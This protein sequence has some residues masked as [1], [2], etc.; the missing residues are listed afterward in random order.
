MDRH[1]KKTD[2]NKTVQGKT[3]RFHISELD[4]A[5]EVAQIRK[6]L[7]GFQGIDSLSFHILDSFVEVE[8]SPEVT[9]TEAI[10][11]QLISTGWTATLHNNSYQK[12]TESFWK[13]NNRLILTILA[14]LFLFMGVFSNFILSDHKFSLNVFRS[15]SHSETDLPLV[16]Q[17]FYLLSITFGGFPV[18]LRAIKSVQQY[19]ADMN[20]L[21]TVA[22]I[23]AL[24]IN[25]WL[26][27][28]MVTFLFAISL[29]LESWSTGQAKKAISNLVSHMP[30]KVLHRTQSE[31]DSD[32]KESPVS[33]IK[34]GDFIQVQPGDK[35]PLDGTVINGESLVD[36]SPITGESVPVEKNEG[37]EVFAGTLNTTGTLEIQVTKLSDESLLANIQK[38]VL[39]AQANQAPVEQTV[40]KFAR[41]YTPIMLVISFLIMTV[42]PL[43]FHGVWS[44]WFYK[45]LVILVIACPCALVISTP[46][47][48]VSALSSAAR[49][50]I[51]IKGGRYLEQAA[52][53]KTIA[54][55][56]T[57][58]ITFGKPVIEKII[59]LNNYQE[60]QLLEIAASI[61]SHSPHPFSN[62]IVNYAINN[63]ISFKQAEEYQYETGQ[64]GRGIVH[65]KEYWVGGLRMLKN[66][67]PGNLDQIEKIRNWETEGF[68][69][70]LIGNKDHLAGCILFRDSLRPDSIEMIRTLKKEKISKTVLL[71]GDNKLTA[72]RIGKETGI[73]TVYAELMP[74]EKSKIIQQLKN[75]SGPVM[76]VGDG[77]ND[78]PAMAISDLSLSMGKGTDIAIET[79]DMTLMNENLKNI[80][81]LIR[82]SRRTIQIIRQNITFALGIKILFLLL[83]VAG[84][85]SMWLAILADTGASLIVVAN[86][87]RLLSSD[88]QIT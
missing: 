25:E 52:S 9:D 48:I 3:E 68:S 12:D 46:V 19:R 23:G 62:A 54:F 56:K 66:R 63:K 16:T 85:A 72:Q 77:I 33:E 75:E 74:D 26:E 76:M 11:T 37:E 65:G 21:M 39:K 28:V 44:E 1:L 78:A 64:G 4:C 18:V 55:D 32:W 34:K 35:I 2:I 57:G 47:S 84:F 79:S 51:L 60:N 81:G 13:K 43:L 6:S 8:Y 82:L 14:G 67:L 36:Q 58:T 7:E 15:S 30:D 41:V 88:T 61:E 70:I 83:T 50:G 59:S 29:A 24:A 38:T 45:S 17:V 71:T 87:L 42:P 22:V 86:G 31:T 5:S 40:E 53:I 80:P 20:V 27:G 49:K 10:Q 69:T 73:E